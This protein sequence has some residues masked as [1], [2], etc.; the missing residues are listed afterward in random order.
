M[1]ADAYREFV[2]D[3]TPALSASE[4]CAISD[5]GGG[6][7]LNNSFNLRLLWAAVADRAAD[8]LAQKWG[9]DIEA[10]A[11]RLRSM[12]TSEL[13]AVREVIQR[14]LSAAASGSDS[15]PEDLLRTCGARFA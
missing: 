7:V 11:G 4:W 2:A 10:L 13:L 15:T 6:A 3:N 1:I 9:V 12:R 8:G 5:A 14:Y